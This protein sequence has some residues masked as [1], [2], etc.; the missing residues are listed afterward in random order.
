MIEETK[1]P[2]D[3]FLELSLYVAELYKKQ[4]DSEFVI[5]LAH[6]LRSAA[7]EAIGE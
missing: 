4:F 3:K 7:L 5:N 6:E 1:L 2:L